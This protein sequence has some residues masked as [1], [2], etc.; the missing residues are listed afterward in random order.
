MSEDYKSL[1]KKSI[2]SMEF[3]Y[4]PYSNFKVGVALL[5]K[6]GK[7]YTGSNIEC[8]SYSLTIC[9]ERVVAAKAI[10]EGEKNF[11]A[12]AISTNRN[13]IAF[14]CGACRQFLMEFSPE[15]KIILTKS[16]KDYQIF[17]LKDLLPKHFKL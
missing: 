16:E 10:S 12:M 15:L 6:S 17:R 8:S 9:A 11:T 7:I 14:P 5:T 3:A 2:S 4:S 1:I 13:K